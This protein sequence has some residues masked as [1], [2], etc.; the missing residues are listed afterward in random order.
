MNPSPSEKIKTL[1]E[2][3]KWVAQERQAGRRIAVTN[4]VFDLLHRGHVEYL[5]Q[6]A[7]EADSLVVAL[8]SDRSVHQL[9]GPERPV[10]NEHDRAYLLAGLECV[11]AV[12][13]FDDVRATEIFRVLKPEVY[14]KGGDYTEESLDREEYAVLKAAGAQFR[15]IPFIP[16]RS[17]TSVIRHIRGEEAPVI[18]SGTELAPVL[19]RR[20]VRQFQLRP[21]SDDLLARILQGAMS[22][23]SACAKDPWE[24]IVLKDEALRRAVAGIL[25][26]GPFL[27]EAPTGIIV[28]GDLQQAHGGEL[29]YLLQDCSA[30]TENLLLSAQ[31]LGLGA[32]WLGIHPRPERIAGV[33]HLCNLPENIVPVS[34][35]ALGWP[36]Q[37][38]APR[39]R[40]NPAKVHINGYR[41]A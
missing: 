21:V 39:T 13:V 38:P 14:V 1:A 33:R 18:G 32:C 15:F 37:H 16:G 11:A 30:A 6:A 17:T 10:V 5:N 26:N 4:G 27:A 34:G 41:E 20:S 35:I 29:S 40:F 22:A 9:K 25:P 7:Q 31:L 23:P 8:N 24:F 28:C 3:L 12:V 19:A 36:A 2:A